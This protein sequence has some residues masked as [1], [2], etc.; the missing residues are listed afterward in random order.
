[1]LLES[2]KQFQI[3]Y[4]SVPGKQLLYAGKRSPE[5]VSFV[6]FFVKTLMKGS[7]LTVQ[8]KG[9]RPMGAMVNVVLHE[10]QKQLN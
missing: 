1:M 7:K 6:S 5:M 8:K 10:L 4:S 9:K 2:S 3:H